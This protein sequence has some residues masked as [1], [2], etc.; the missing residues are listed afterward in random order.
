MSILR[1]V[2]KLGL[3][4]FTLIE[5]SEDDVEDNET[6]TEDGDNEDVHSDDWGN[7]QEGQEN[8]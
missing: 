1:E 7:D 3:G 5:R 2:R 4:I 6:S 8:S